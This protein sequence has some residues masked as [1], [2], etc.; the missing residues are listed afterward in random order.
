MDQRYIEEYFIDGPFKSGY[1]E[2]VIDS[3]ADAALDEESGTMFVIPSNVHLREMK[4]LRKLTTKTTGIKTLLVVRV[5]AADGATTASMS[6][7]SDSVFGTYGDSFNL[8]SQYSACSHN[9]LNFVPAKGAK[10]ING[11]REVTISTFTSDGDAKMNNAILQALGKKPYRLADHLMFCLPPG[12]MKYAY[13][14]INGPLSVYDDAWCT[15][16]SPGM[17]EIGHNLG[18][19]CIFLVQFYIYVHSL[20][21]F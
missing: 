9:K 4:Q 11:V 5:V 6:E 14:T 12:T 21:L 16:P 15:Y 1:A 7:L 20:Y 17:H 13:A 3:N 18:R 8:A 19:C 10:I 2:L